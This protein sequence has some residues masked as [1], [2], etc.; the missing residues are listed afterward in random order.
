MDFKEDLGFV[1]HNSDLSNDIDKG[2]NLCKVIFNYFHSLNN[3]IDYI[4]S[5]TLKLMYYTI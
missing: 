1:I 4:S 5:T 2:Y 3:V